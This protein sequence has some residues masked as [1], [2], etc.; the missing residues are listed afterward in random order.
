M[1][2]SASK[3]LRTLN[4]LDTP[5]DPRLDHI[6]EFSANEFSVPICLVTLI[7]KDRQWCKSVYGNIS[8]ECPREIS[9]C[10]HAIYQINTK[11][12]F[13]RVFEVCNTEN[14]K[15]FI[16][17]PLVTGE[18]KIRSYIAYVLQSKTGMN[19]GGFCLIDNKPRKYSG[20]EVFSLVT[21]GRI[22]EDILN[23]VC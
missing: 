2:N 18:R 12:P 16:E 5:D 13:N 11:H 10:T 4:C 19:L 8:K 7:D 6:T 3:T 17:N 21:I 20:E 23:N 14:D 9:F 1:T 15:R 22:V